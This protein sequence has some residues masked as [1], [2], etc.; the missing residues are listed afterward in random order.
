M[1]VT[2]SMQCFMALFARAVPDP[3]V[4]V[5]VTQIS[6]GLMPRLRHPPG[7]ATTGHSRVAVQVLRVEGGSV[8]AV[9]TGERL[10]S[11]L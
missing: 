6:H 3:A 1:V 2:L 5:Q 9:V 4:F 10:K 11:C 8:D 7:G